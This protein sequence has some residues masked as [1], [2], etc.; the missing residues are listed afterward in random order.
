[1]NV[2]LHETYRTQRH[3]DEFSVEGREVIHKIRSTHLIVQIDH[4]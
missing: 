2:T 1:M 4:I 3:D